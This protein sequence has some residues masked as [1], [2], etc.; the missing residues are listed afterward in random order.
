M[1]MLFKQ[2]LFSWFD[3]YDIYD[4]TGRPLY[5]VKGQLAWGHCLQVYDANGAHVGTVKERILTL[6][7]KFEIYLN[8]AYVGCVS[9]ELTLFRPRY[10]ID[11]LGWQVQGSLMEWDYSITDARGYQVAEV[12][13]ELL[14]WTDTYTIDV[15]R[16][17]DALPALMFVLAVDAEKCSRSD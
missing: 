13:K 1:R 16:R 15:S 4:E 10:R 9:R 5:T 2:R 11:F 7:P 3:S 17:E 8:G 12:S 14:H 6:L